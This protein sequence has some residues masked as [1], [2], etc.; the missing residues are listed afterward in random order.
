ML[1]DREK[2]QRRILVAYFRGA[3]EKIAAWSMDQFARLSILEGAAGVDPG[4]WLR[5]KERGFGSALDHFGPKL[6]GAWTASTDQGVYDKAVAAATRMLQGVTGT[7]G[8]D[9][10]QDLVSG[11]ASAG[12]A[13]R[14]RMFYA[15]GTALRKY[16][17]DLGQGAITPNHR[18]IMGTIEHWVRRA[19]RDVL[20]SWGERRQES[21]DVEEGHAHRAPELDAEKRG[22]L[23]LLALQS[24]GGP[25]IE[26]R[27][28]LDNL[29]DSAFSTAD[30]PLVRA[31]LEK[32][33]QPKYRSQAE[34]KKIVTHFTPAKWF[35]QAYQHVRKELMDEF[36]VSAQRLTNALGGNAKNVFRFMSEKVGRDPKIQRIVEE[37]ADEIELLEPGI[38]RIAKS[39]SE[40]VEKWL[41]RQR[42]REREGNLDSGSA[43]GGLEQDFEKDDMYDWQHVVTP[44]ANYARGP[45]VL[46]VATAWLSARGQTC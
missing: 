19:A 31:F 43:L 8:A 3:V 11:S 42:D 28:I 46:R 45:V 24:P 33:S 41:E 25:G 35:T 27:R 38:A 32:I 23:L 5:Q 16:E 40:I 29:I 34:M 17:N 13:A 14:N 1:D 22:N 15:V 30:R 36:G 12:G 37:I 2:V 6:A 18:L 10:V 21:F 7:D 9:L 20:H 39:R 44:Y 4:H 26:V